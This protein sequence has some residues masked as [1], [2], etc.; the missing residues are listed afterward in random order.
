MASVR[1]G[2]LVAAQF[3]PIARPQLLAVGFT[4]G[5]VESWLRTGRLHFTRFP[6][7]YAAGRP[8]LPEE[9]D[10]SAALLFAG[11]GCGLTGVSGLWWRG[12]LHRRPD[13]IHVDS[14][15]RSRSY[16]DLR[17][18]HPKRVDREGHRGLP[19]S[20]LPATL[21]AA[22]EHLRHNSLRLVIARA[23]FDRK[24]TLS[25]IEAACG[26]GF[27][28]S[29]K[30]RA[31]LAAHLPQLAKCTNRLEREY[32]LLCEAHRLPIPE[33]NERIGRYRPDMLWADRMLIV[34]LDGPRAHSTPA[35]LMA[36]AARQKFLESLGYTVVRFTDEDVFGRPGWVM[37]QTREALAAP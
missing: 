19:V 14:P 35:Q 24:I 7:V 15:T 32:V 12:Y 20:A 30:L 1:A 26:R 34:E 5:R 27:A 6:G 9:G 4:P 23:E 2:K 10:L 37:A 29:S 3:G 11:H 16:A 36:D 28:G 31:A 18:R 25:A 22:T 13:L 17:I 33:P 8:D 21:L